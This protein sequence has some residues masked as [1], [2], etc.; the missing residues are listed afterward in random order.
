MRYTH[1]MRKRKYAQGA[2]RD[3]HK[4]RLNIRHENRR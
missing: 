2:L 1:N 4:K 3:T